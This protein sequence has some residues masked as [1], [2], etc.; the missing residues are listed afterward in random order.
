MEKIARVTIAKSG[1]V[2]FG[3]KNISISF[4]NVSE[5]EIKRLNKLYRKK[6]APTDVLSFA[7]FTPLNI[8]LRGVSAKG[9]EFNRVKNKKEIEKGKNKNHESLFLGEIV[10]CYNDIV[11][12]SKE[13]KL[14]K[15]KELAKAI[16]HGVLHLLGFRHGKKM[17]EIQNGIKFYNF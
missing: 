16:S 14:D 1:L 17:F 6:N 11:K 15:E 10:L 13:Y 7:E 4:A 2:K 3:R 9:G 5:E 12:Y 8:P